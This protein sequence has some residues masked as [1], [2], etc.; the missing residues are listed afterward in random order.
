MIDETARLAVVG[1]VLLMIAAPSWAGRD[2]GGHYSAQRVANLRANVEQYDWAQSQRDRYVSSAQRWVEMSDEELWRLIPCQTLPRCIDVT[3]TARKGQGNFRMGCLV[4]GDDV[5]KHGNYPYRPNCAS[6]PWKLTCPSCGTVFPTNDFAAFYES[7]LDEHGCFNRDLGDKS[8][9]FNAEHPDPN[10][11]LHKWGVDD[12]W[13]YIDADGHEHRYIAY[14]TWKL[15][16]YIEGGLGALAN[17]Y[18]YTGDPI[19]AHKAGVMLDRL[20]DV[21]PAMDWAPYAEMGWFHSDGGSGKGKIEGRIWETGDIRRLATAYDMVADGLDDCPELLEFLGAMAE[22][23]DLPGEKG[24]LEDLHHNIEEGILRTGAEA[25]ISGQIR[26]NEG[27]YQSAMAAVAM[28]FGRDPE[29]SEWMDWNFAPDGGRIPGIIIG[30]IDRD[31][32]G[33]EGAPSY[34]LGWASNIGKLADMLADYADYDNHDIYR[35]YPSF[36]KTFAAGYGLVVLG[37]ATPNIGDCG[38]TGSMGK[39]AA[40]PNFIARGYRYLHDPEIGLAVWRANDNSVEGLKPDIWAEDPNA[41]IDEIAAIGQAADGADEGGGFNRAGYGLMSLERGRGSTGTALWMMYGRSF[42][43]GHHDRLN[44]GVYGFGLKLSPDLGY[45]EFASRWPKRGEWTDNTICHNTVI[46]DGQPQTANWSGH[47]VFFKTL[48]GLSAGEVSSPNV[49]EQC[50]VYARTIALIGV[51]DGDAYGLDLFRVRGGAEHLLSFHALPGDPHVDRLMPVEQGEGTYA[52]PEVAFG[53]RESNDVPLGYSWLYGVARDDNPAA[54]WMLDWQAP[55][56]YRGAKAADEIHLVYHHLT[57]CDEV[58][59]AWGDPPQNKSGNPRRLRYALAK[60]TGDDGLASTFVSLHEP[61]RGDPLIDSLERL[62]A[63]PDAAGF[64]AVTVRVNLADGATDYLV[65]CSGGE[66]VEAAEDLS[67]D[68]RL[69]FVRVRNGVVE[70]AAIIGGTT[71][72][73]GEFRLQADE[74]TLTGTVV[75][76]DMDSED[77]GRIWV[78]TELPD[79]GTLVGQQITIEN[80]GMRDATYTIARVERDGEATMLSLGAVSFVRGFVDK[81]DYSKGYVYNFEEGAGFTIVGHAWVERTG[82]NV[83]DVRASAG[84]DVQL[85]R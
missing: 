64:E 13:G 24:S 1:I 31:G 14:Y 54:Q 66:L 11:P 7:A 48:P 3:M 25:I 45:P 61:Y 42:G 15:W 32:V 44:I 55:D 76:M 28:A 29:M 63:G 74:P 46:V 33:A 38:S 19:Y 49:Y 65:S 39:V 47:S 68:C 2:G 81:D 52:G 40:D 60:R 21:Y 8:L 16:G 69:G 71:L 78:D 4:C 50:D 17:A 59:L 56:G 10:D 62:E 67:F 9:L 41:Y 77:D 20:A 85:G 51:G 23:Y 82:P 35:D 22:Q 70:R 26:G 53:K 34:S 84:A 36:A 5:F 83:A 57:P 37:L 72:A 43:H 75:R 18:L 27:M 12:G 6:L 79:D 58:A 80:D 30:R 73:L